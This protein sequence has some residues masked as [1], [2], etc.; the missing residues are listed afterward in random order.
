MLL[1]QVKRFIPV[2][3]AEYQGGR[4]SVGNNVQSQDSTATDVEV[5]LDQHLY[6]TFT[7]YDDE[8]SLGFQP[9]VEIYLE[10]AM[11][12]I[13]QM[14]DEIIAGTAVRFLGTNVGQLGSAPDISTIL[15]LDEVM[16]NNKVP[17]RGRNLVLSTS[18]QAD[19]L[20]IDAFHEAHKLSDGGQAIREAELGR[21]FGFNTFMD[22]NIPSVGENTQRDAV[23]EIDLG[24]GYAKGTV[25]VAVDGFSAA[26]RNGSWIKIEGDDTPLQVQSTTGGA[27]PATITFS[28]GL[29]RAVAD[30]ADV[31]VYSSALV[32]KVGD[33]AA[34]SITEVTFDAYQS[35][36]DSAT[37]PTVG[38]M[39]SFALTSPR[40]TVL[41]SFSEAGD[42]LPNTTDYHLNDALDAG[43]SND[44]VIGFGPEGSYSFGFTKNALTMVSRPL[45]IPSRD[46]GVMSAVANN[47]GVGVRVSM[48]Y[49]I[50]S[51][52]TIV[53]VDLLM[54]C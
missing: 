22:Q 38:Q 23:G 8:L 50:G 33:Y 15:A 35:V 26:I 34:D 46:M 53:T 20:N 52:G 31:T 37:T 42:Q 3:P 1:A 12:S 24:A 48:Q 40:Y 29:S 51:Q 45:A 39:S 25:T 30:D 32:N 49:D 9:L 44:D 14:I 10:P 2:N 41:E 18:A 6:K 21:K 19:L 7:I 5:K 13:A 36:L 4:K 28:P 11:L 16:N 27:T 43:I 47:R 54:G 17:N